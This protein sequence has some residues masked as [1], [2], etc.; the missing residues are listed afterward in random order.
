MVFKKVDTD[1]S[2][3]GTVKLVMNRGMTAP[4][5]K[6]SG[7]FGYEVAPL[8]RV[9]ECGGR[10]CGEGGWSRRRPPWARK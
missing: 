5:W 3:L 4:E 8:L 6:W 10:E 7:G 9:V 1:Q 2:T